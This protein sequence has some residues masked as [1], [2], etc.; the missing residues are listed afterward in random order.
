[1]TADTAFTIG[2]ETEGDFAL[3]LTAGTIYALK[4]SKEGYFTN[5][6]SISTQSILVDSL[7]QDTLLLT[8][9]ILDKTFTGQEITL[10]NIYYDYDKSDI[11]AD[12]Q[13]TLNALAQILTKNPQ[14]RIQ[15]G[16][17]TDCRGKDAYNLTLSQQRAESAVK[18]LSA[19]NINPVR[20]VAKG[21]GETRPAETCKCETCTED[22]HQKN[23]RTTFM[24]LE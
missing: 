24:V 10:E 18:Y 8:E 15:L 4:A 13:P 22:Q 11:R 5:E 20:L 17:H 3:T 23:R 21:F 7:Q 14:I 6:V 16:S 9:I 1:M 19:Q 2:T 12:A